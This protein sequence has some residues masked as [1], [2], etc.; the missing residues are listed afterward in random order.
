MQQSFRQAAVERGYYPIIERK[1]H[2]M[3]RGLLEAPHD[4]VKHNK[5]YDRY[6]HA[7]HYFELPKHL[8]KTSHH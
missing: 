3:L 1:I 2:Q 6:F 8:H 7:A 5:M 4:F